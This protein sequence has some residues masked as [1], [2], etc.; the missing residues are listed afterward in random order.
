MTLPDRSAAASS[1]PSG[2]ELLV[3]LGEM[4]VSAL[5]PDALHGSFEL[6]R[7]F[8]TTVAQNGNARHGG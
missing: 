5:D 8:P 6:Y 1:R 7:A 4:V 3:H 2:D